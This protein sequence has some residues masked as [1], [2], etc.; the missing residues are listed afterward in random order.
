[1]GM[2]LEILVYANFRLIS[3]SFFLL[4]IRGR[5]TEEMKATDSAVV[6][7]AEPLKI[8]ELAQEMENEVAGGQSPD[9]DNQTKCKICDK[10]FTRPYTLKMHILS[11]HLNKKPFHCQVCSAGFTRRDTL[12][13]H[14]VWPLILFYSFSLL[15]VEYY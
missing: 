11:T 1:M 3:F 15:L 14:Q 6:D 12:K 5:R 9:K 2:C 13:K 4:Q 10:S 8:K 7:T